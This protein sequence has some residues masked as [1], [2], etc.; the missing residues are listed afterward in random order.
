MTKDV[1]RY[2]LLIDGE[3]I[4]SE[5]IKTIIEEIAFKGEATIRRIYGNWTEPN[6]G[7]WKKILLDY[8]ITPIQQFNNTNGKNSTDSALII[9]AMDILYSGNVDG[10]ALVSSDSDFT[11]LASRL[12]ESGMTVVGMG[13]DKT[14]DAFVKA[15]TEFKYLKKKKA[16]ST[17][18]NGAKP[19]AK[20][21]E[22]VQLKAYVDTIDKVID[23][24][25]D[26]NGWVKL[27]LVGGVLKNQYPE[28]T[29]QNYGYSKTTD[30]VKHLGYEI[31][32]EPDVNNK[33]SPNGILVY[34][35]KKK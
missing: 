5:Y 33:K 19:I 18:T 17:K 25:S 11:R 27:S 9:D 30:F 7:P 10:F 21:K 3:N 16:T 2:A 12:R 22:S 31:R 20:D 1:Y 15:C 13:E 34:I 35:K 26:K 14:P 24:N 32:E 4:S 8:S 6:L 23:E 29:P 28:F